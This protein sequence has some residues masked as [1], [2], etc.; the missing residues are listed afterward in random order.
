MNSP[1][2]F[3]QSGRRRRLVGRLTA[4]LL[5]LVL[6]SATVF[7]TTIV[8]VPSASPL[9]FGRERSQPLPFK[10]HLAHLTHHLPSL[11]WH[12]GRSHPLQ[13]GF[14]VPW[15]EE[16]ALSL[17]AH[18]DQLDWVVAS[19]GEIDPASGMLSVV[20][21]PEVSAIRRGRLH[22]VK[23]FLM[24]QNIHQGRWYGPQMAHIL[25]NRQ[26]SDRL[27][28]QT[29]DAARKLQWQ[30][31]VFDLEN[32]P[33][34]TLPLY[35]Q[36]LERAHA[37]FT[38]AGLDLSLTVPAGEASW[39]LHQM[40][41]AVDHVFFM[42][43][44]QH[45]QGGEPGPI[46]AQGWFTQQLAHAKATIPDSKLIIALGNYG[47]DWHDG[48]ADALT[49]NDAWLAARD[50]GSMP[51]FDPASGN[52]GFAYEED[53]AKHTIWLMDAATSW[54]Q[55]QLLD[56]IGGI[57]LWR[58]GS[59]DPGYWDAL[60]AMRSGSMP[61]LSNISPDPGTDVEGSGEILRIAAE[62]QG[63]LRE[64]EFDSARTITGEKYRALPSPYVV[65]RTGAK[66][67]HAIALTFDDGPDA[68]L[69]SENPLDP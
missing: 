53:G 14:Y 15:D 16:S 27:I 50:S 46:A 65:Q 32:L 68:D 42:D 47:Y 44:D 26:A 62:P 20:N 10:T 37:R 54:N 6:I 39:H 40:A 4:L 60:K 18:Y 2:F 13:I 29:I 1:V 36:F 43:Y 31:A 61:K 57:A 8:E 17:R 3:D 9:E 25:G 51:E 35:R 49:I 67:P 19:N 58:L 63:G 30:G 66:D 34:S 21:D 7:A 52:S 28:T 48:T 38:A 55:I 56:G 33:D 59:E 23:Y 24:V 45:W 64:V 69:Y 5:V 11:P 12:I 41:H 22:Q